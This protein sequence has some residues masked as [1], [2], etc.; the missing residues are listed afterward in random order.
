MKKILIGCIAMLAACGHRENEGVFFRHFQNEYSRADDTIS[1]ENGIVTRK[2]GYNKIRN[3]QLK[4]REYDV[5]KWRLNE[6][7]SAVIVIQ[8]DELLMGNS[9]YKRIN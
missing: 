5:E 7:G 9:R 6:W 4:P 3:G 1:I 8:A 2:T